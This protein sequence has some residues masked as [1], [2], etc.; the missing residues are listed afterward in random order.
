MLEMLTSAY[1]RAPESAIGKLMRIVADLLEESFGSLQKVR[2]WRDIDQAQGTTLDKWGL[3]CGVARE[4]LP[5]DLY[6]L[7][8]K[9]KMAAMISGGDL[10]TLFGAISAIT[11][12]ERGELRAYEIF[13]AKVWLTIPIEKQD[14]LPVSASLLRRLIKRL[15]AAGIGYLFAFEDDTF[16]SVYAG[17]RMTCVGWAKFD[18]TTPRKLLYVGTSLKAVAYEVF[19]M[20]MKTA[21]AG[22]D[23]L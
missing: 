21:Q 15:L 9:V 14:S 12:I 8:I 7:V 3:N 6:R 23:V 1:A 16:V 22:G 4:G 17:T 18:M 5:D 19:D 10:E 11:G 2:L 20:R 13:P